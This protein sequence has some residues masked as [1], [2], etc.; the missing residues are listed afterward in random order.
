MEMAFLTIGSSVLAGGIYGG[1]SGFVRGLG[2]TKT[3]SKNV[4]NTQ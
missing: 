2:E 4:R 3:L 1:L